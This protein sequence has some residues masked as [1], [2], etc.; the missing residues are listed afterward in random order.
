ML[1]DIISEPNAEMNSA[2]IISLRILLECASRRLK[3][4]RPIFSSFSKEPL[5]EIRMFMERFIQTESAENKP[6]TEI[7]IICWII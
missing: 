4:A 6:H 3:A 1:E 2:R 7:F 5:I